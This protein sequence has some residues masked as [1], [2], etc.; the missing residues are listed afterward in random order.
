M[1]TAF[2]VLVRPFIIFAIKDEVLLHLIYMLTS[3]DLGLEE[4]SRLNIA[5][6]SEA[7]RKRIHV[8]TDS[9]DVV[10]TVKVILLEP[11]PLVTSREGL[12]HA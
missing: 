10:P 9:R 6:L 5:Y 8:W 7:K 3:S 4:S 2:S 12:V 1:G 11:Y